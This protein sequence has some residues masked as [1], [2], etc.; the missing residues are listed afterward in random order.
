[1]CGKDADIDCRNAV[2]VLY[3]GITAIYCWTIT[4][5][6]TESYSTR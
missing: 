5:C 6:H 2:N 4:C 1:M 3:R